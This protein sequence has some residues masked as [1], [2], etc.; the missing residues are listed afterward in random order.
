MAASMSLTAEDALESLA[1][2]G[3]LRAAPE[4]IA[5]SSCEAHLA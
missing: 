3:C 2:L 4:Y 5:A 1:L